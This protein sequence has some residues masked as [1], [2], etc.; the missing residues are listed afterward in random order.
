[1][2]LAWA[3]TVHKVQ[4]LTLSKVVFSFDLLRQRKFNFG[5]GYVALSRV[6]RLSD[7]FLTGDISE[8][9]IRVDPRVEIEY[10]RLRNSQHFEHCVASVICESNSRNFVISLLNVRSMKR[11]YFD[12]RHQGRTETKLSASV[13]AKRDSPI[14]IL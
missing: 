11:L 8:S 13:P 14:T 3:C 9:S 12:I 2:T 4:G 5:Q 10:Q 7:L 6:R 1:M